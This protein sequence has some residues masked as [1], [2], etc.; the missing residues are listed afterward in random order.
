MT[1][2]RS[3]LT[4]ISLATLI[5]GVLAATSGLADAPGHVSPQKSE[6]AFMKAAE[7]AAKNGDVNSAIAFYRKAAELAPKD[8][9]PMAELGDLMD[10]TGS[11]GGA[12]E[13]YRA[14]LAR[15]P[16]AWRIS[17]ELGRLALK[18][19]RPQDAV[20]RF[21]TAASQHPE[22]A[23]YNG[24]GVSL[25]LTGQHA[26]AQTAYQQ[27]LKLS[28]IDMTLRNNL[29]L[30][31]ALAGDYP[32]AIAT[33]SALAAEP[34]A[35][36]R[37]RLNLALA[38]GLSGDDDKAAQAAHEDLGQDQIAS[39]RR[40]YQV[41]RSLGDRARSEAILGGKSPEVVH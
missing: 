4:L 25:D 37:Y 9:A 39:N 13:A 29:G 8:P 26:R 5:A 34:Q 28:P 21:E 33:L 35:A 18:L 20:A 32:A 2:L 30:S 38:Y 14:A 22:A 12:V 7:A 15:A 40:Y 31:Q 10:H 1:R 6:D 36:P 41:L 19:D 27:G 23:A 16:N 3:P 17:L 11:L 24:L